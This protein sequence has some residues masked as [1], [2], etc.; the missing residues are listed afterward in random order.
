MGDGP[1]K[2]PGARDAFEARGRIHPHVHKTPLAR[3]DYFDNAV[4]ARILFKCENL[5]KTGSFKARGATNTVFGLSDDEAARGVVAHSSGNH[6][7]A[8]AYA[9]RRRGIPSVVVMPDAAVESKRAAVREYGGRVVDCAA[10]VSARQSAAAEVVR[11]TGAEFVHPYDD[12]RVI[13]GQATCALELLEQTG[14]LDAIVVPIGGGGLASGTC[15][16]VEAT[17]AHAQVI[18]AEPSGADDAK[19]SLEAGRL[20]RCDAPD[21][22]A[23]G[24]RTPLS[25]LTW[26]FV[27]SRVD[28]ILTADDQEAVQA[29]K[30]MLQRMKMLVEPS[31]A[32]AVAAVLGNARLFKGKKVGVVLSGGNADIRRLPWTELDTTPRAD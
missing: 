17:G 4:G 23:D 22:I 9:A 3:S 15:V 26:Q 32:V 24:L 6:G 10:T 20:V 1:M 31:A 21:T 29:M 12:P 7:Q 8:L 14:E 2:L 19:K 25:D 18:G 27:S 30:I 16:A 11:E 5:Q 28:R 13:A